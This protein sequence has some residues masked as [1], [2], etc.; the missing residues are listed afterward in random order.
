MTTEVIIPLVNEEE[1][2]I[3]Y[4][5]VVGESGSAIGIPYI[6]LRWNS[7]EIT[8]KNIK[9]IISI[10]NNTQIPDWPILGAVKDTNLIVT[11]RDLG[12]ET[13]VNISYTESKMVRLE[14]SES[15]SEIIF[16]VEASIP[17]LFSS[18][19]GHWF[20]YFNRVGLY[21]V[22]VMDDDALPDF[23]RLCVVKHN[24][25]IIRDNRPFP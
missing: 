24:I 23:N 21:I 7:D 16:D 9:K 18:W 5:G 19:E 20:D 22:T 2:V 4:T 6:G 8:D 10:C 14:N 15:G 25:N 1:D 13:G 12:L 17:M 11:I 3:V